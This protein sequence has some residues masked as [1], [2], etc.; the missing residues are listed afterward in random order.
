MG[1][2]SFIV[3]G[4]DGTME[5]SFRTQAE[6]DRWEN[7]ASYSGSLG[8]KDAVVLLTGWIF[9]NETAAAEYAA[10]VL[11]SDS[12]I[13]DKY[14]PAGAVAFSGGWVFVGFAAS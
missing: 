10:S 12:R 9:P 14:G 5:E 2:M 7:G 6:S 4:P 11:E 3:T 13:Q 1:A 8:M